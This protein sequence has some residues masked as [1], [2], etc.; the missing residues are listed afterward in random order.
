MNFLKKWLVLCWNI[1][2]LNAKSKQLAL[3]NAIKNS[4]CAVIC[5]QETKKDVFDLQFIKSCCPPDFDEF[6]YVSSTGASGGL[7][8]IWKGSIFSG[9][10]M[11]CEPFALSVHFTS[12]QSSQ[13]WT[14]VNVY[15][16][17]TGEHREAFIQWLYDLNI[18]TDE[19]W[20]IAGDFNFI[21]SPSNRNKPGGNVNDMLIFNDIIRSQNLTELA[22]KGRKYTWSNMQQDPLLEQLDWFFTSPHWTISYPA[23]TVMTQCK[24][25]SD[26]TPCIIS[27]ETTIP[28]SKLFRFESFWAA[29]PGFQQIVADSWSKP[30]H[31]KNSA[32]NLNAKFKR[33]RHD[34]NHW[35]KSISKLSICIENTS[36]AIAEIDKLEETRTLSLPEVNF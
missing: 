22:I 18:P 26:H 24:P 33:L 29:H 5:L 32:A 9:L 20:L 1:R 12:T 23:T 17:C 15:G 27:I 19:D 6:V 14:L 10:V 30:T 36:Q 11:H 25:T 2:G 28:G 21:R 8:I 3:M 31:K 4:G 34:L 7:I 35:S 13:S 16:P